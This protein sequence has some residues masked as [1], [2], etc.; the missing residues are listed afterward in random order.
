M[1]LSGI[2]LFRRIFVCLSIAVMLALPAAAQITTGNLAGTVTAQGDAL[3]GV[4]IEVVHVPTGTQYSTVSGAN[5]RYTIPNV[6]VGGPYTITAALEGFRTTKLTGID[7]RLGTTTEAPIAMQLAAVAESITV[8]ASA[9]TVLNP[10][11]TGSTSAVSEAQIE[12]LPTVNRSLQDY[13]R[14]NPYF[15]VSPS[16]ESG[17][18]MNVAGKNAR[19][20]NIQIDGAVNNDL[21]GLASSGTPGGQANT[22]PV[23]LDA[24]EQLQLVVSPYDVRQS[25]F[26]GGGVN[27]VTR[28]GTNDLK[29][30]VF[31]TKRDQQFVGDGPFDR[32]ISNF[33]HTQYGGRVGGPV[34]HD[35]LFFFV[36]GEVNRREQPTGVSAD[37]STG[38]VYRAPADV[39][40][41]ADVLKTKYGYDPG[42]LGDISGKTNSDLIFGR[43]DWNAGNRNQITF[44]HNYVKG[45]FDN[46]SNRSTGQFRFPSSIYTFNSKTGSTVAQ[47]NSVF[48]AN[49][50]NEGRVNYTTIRDARV[51][52]VA[53]PSIEIGGREQSADINAGTERFSGANA[54]DQDILEVTDDFTFITGNHNI[55]IGTSNQIFDFGNLFLSDFYGYYF[56]PTLAD[57]DAGKATIYRIGFVNDASDPGRKTT[58]GVA[59][60]GLY[61]GDQW[62]ISP[63][64]SLTF[65]LR[66][67]MPRYKDTPAHNPL[68][69]TALGLNT[70]TVPSEDVV[71]S[72]RIG[73][74]WQIPGNQQLR[75]GVGIFAGRT[76]YVWVS[77][78]Y[79]NTG[80]ETSQLGCLKS[81]NCTP[82]DF[83]PDPNAQPRNLGSAGAPT[84]DLVSGDFEMPRILRATLGYDRELFFGVRGSIEGIWSKTQ[85]DVY[86]QNVNK[87]LAGTNSVD[88][89]PTYTRV[90]TSI[91]DAL[92]LTNTDKGEEKMWSIQLN[93]PFARGL[94]L[95]A[96]YMNQ[97]A[98]SAFDT[99]SSR[100][101]SNWRF[102]VTKGDIF[103]PELGRSSWE[104]K[105]RFNIAATYAF[106][107]GPLRHNFGLFYN[108]QSGD[109]YSLLMSGDPNG[110]GNSSN[111]LLHVPKSDSEVILQNA[112]R[113]V[114]PYST[115]AT[116][117][118]SVG[119]NGTAGKILDKNDSFEP[120][121]RQ[122]DL[123]YELGL[124]IVGSV[125]TQITF[126]ILNL[127]NMFDK[128]SGVVK[129]V[130]FQT[131]TPIFYAGKDTATGKAIYRENFTGALTP[132]RQ[133][134]TA[135]FR[136]RWN[137]RIGLRVNF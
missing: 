47:I 21:F 82:P 63:A 59:Q 51:V 134:T 90:S 38:V 126:D 106:T 113:Q 44:R 129:G 92:Y 24:L 5:G 46:I 100:A 62:R 93:R 57:F 26:T 110:D 120:W 27:A 3:P 4:T 20:N 64:V 2:P 40:H 132:G 41:V 77:N 91:V 96:S 111:D 6:R 128:D 119:V 89:R 83:N 101:I 22:Q 135:D 48:S 8:T 75:G 98:K 131:Y 104:V 25:G 45:N 36:S 70:D 127:L 102:N 33:D 14:T 79:Q 85:E 107:T 88:G 43:L 81:A 69:L 73:F 116:F 123:H 61:A 68:V 53:F 121:A 65:G 54:L 49:S 29:G 17:T 105:H 114:V 28:S 97:D 52:P 133:F 66:G 37:N 86:F 87:K 39:A 124:P 10:N 72:P 50:F 31:G 125:N 30:S 136:S 56:F 115:L 23:S 130:A 84:V 19:Y 122:M 99:T 103:N 118:E 95:S 80:I 34:L 16:D 60:Y 1:E 112:A 76:P 42:S 7:V 137:A 74:N 117:L 109:P 108:A 58:F 32:P 13:A 15:V 18:I 12:S 78:A 71:W 11:R 94:T 9:D 67:D 35:R 55:T